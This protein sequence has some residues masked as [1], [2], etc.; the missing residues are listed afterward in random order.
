LW[1]GFGELAHFSNNAK[2]RKIESEWQCVKCEFFR[3]SHFIHVH[4][5]IL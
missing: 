4:F 5:R 2:V 1:I 3:I